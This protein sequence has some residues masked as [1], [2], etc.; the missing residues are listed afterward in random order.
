MSLLV[1][2]GRFQGFTKDGHYK[3]IQQAKKYGRNVVLGIGSVNQP[4]SVKNPFTYFE[5][6]QMIR[7]ALDYDTSVLFRPIR[8]LKDDTDWVIEVKH[9]IAKACETIGVSYE[10]AK[11]ALIGMD[12]DESSY[13]LKY[14]P[15][16]DFIEYEKPESIVSATDARNILFQGM[17]KIEELENIV[18]D[19]TIKFFN[20][21]KESEHYFSLVKD[22]NK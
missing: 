20:K 1:H 22:Y 3:V 6:C 7:E 17:E 11:I 18:H 15:F 10:Y 9:E 5:R 14:F 21:F 2:N 12:K 19:T 8:D 4:R 16:W 13:Y